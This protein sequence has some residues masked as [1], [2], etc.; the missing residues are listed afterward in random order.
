MN[1]KYLVS[2]WQKLNRGD[3]AFAIFGA[4][5]ALSF[6]FIGN[7]GS[8]HAA[9]PQ[10][11]PALTYELAGPVQHSAKVGGSY[12]VAPNLKNLT[13]KQSQTVTP[14]Q[15]ITP[16]QSDEMIYQTFVLAASVFA[17]MISI[18]SMGAGINLGFR[19]AREVRGF[20][21]GGG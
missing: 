14:V 8:A 19:I 4:L 17:S 20:L 12:T 18:I 7:T 15:I 21:S 2:I 10:S 3:M 13:L 9:P 1:T 6:L 11:P 16:A 5:L